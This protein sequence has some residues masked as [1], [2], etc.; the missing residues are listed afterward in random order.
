MNKF[1]GFYRTFKHKL[2]YKDGFFRNIMVV[3]M[4]LLLVDFMVL[5]LIW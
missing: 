2:Q 4:V 3:L 1:V 5:Y